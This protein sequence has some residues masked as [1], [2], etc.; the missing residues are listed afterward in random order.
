M[1]GEKRAEGGR[2]ERR[3]A[4]R[5]IRRVDVS[6]AAGDALCETRGRTG[7][8]GMRLGRVAGVGGEEVLSVWGRMDG[9]GSGGTDLGRAGQLN[10]GGEWQE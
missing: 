6:R 10:P 2:G 4:W 8:G 1:L 7:T 5:E 9:G 3:S